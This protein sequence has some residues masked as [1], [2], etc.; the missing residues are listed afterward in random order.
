[1]DPSGENLGEVSRKPRVI[2][3][4]GAPSSGTRQVKSLEVV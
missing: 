3:R 2:R 4:A 1:M